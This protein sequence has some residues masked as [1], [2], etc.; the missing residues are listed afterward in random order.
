MSSRVNFHWSSEVYSLGKTFREYYKL[1]KWLPL[2]FYS[3]HAPMQSGV[4]DFRISEEAIKGSIYLTFSPSCIDRNASRLNLKILGT[5]H[6]WVPYRRKRYR[7]SGTSRRTVAFFP[8]HSTPQ[9]I[10][11]GFDDL[12]SISRLNQLRN[13]GY[14]PIVCLHWHDLGSERETMFRSAEFEIVTLGNPHEETYVDKFYEL[15]KKIDFLV[16]ESYTSAIPFMIEFGI[17]CSI[18]K[19]EL[20]IHHEVRTDQRFGY[21]DAN[22]KSDINAVEKLFESFPS[23]ISKEHIAFAERELGFDFSRNYYEI[24]RIIFQAYLYK[25]PL[26]LLK[27]IKRKM[28]S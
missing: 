11:N 2:P 3:D 1:P 18:V 8:L 19:R 28:L 20:D 5:L 25:M 15:A 24:R 10:T 23:E 9:Y 12:D 16:S 21:S 6:P 13:I 22:T 14:E 26:T 17:P 4:I 7:R 27:I